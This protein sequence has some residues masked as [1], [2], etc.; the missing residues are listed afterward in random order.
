MRV[1]APLSLD[2]RMGPIASVGGSRVP[3]V[4]V[5]VEGRETGPVGCA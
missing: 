2:G 4:V 3:A 5:A 1:R